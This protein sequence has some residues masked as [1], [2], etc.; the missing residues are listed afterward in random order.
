M[1]DNDKD[2]WRRRPTA[3]QPEAAPNPD[4]DWWR[5][6]RPNQPI[7]PKTPEELAAEAE[8]QYQR[9]W[10]KRLPRKGDSS[11]FTEE[12][13]DPTDAHDWGELRYMREPERGR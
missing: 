13:T 8:L 6:P 5:H 7:P 12:Y 1:G 2:W 10:W 9:D 11:G 3:K 4:R